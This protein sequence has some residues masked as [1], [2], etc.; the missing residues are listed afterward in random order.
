MASAGNE[1]CEGTLSLV[2]NACSSVSTVPYLGFPYTARTERLIAFRKVQLG[3]VFIED[4]FEL[5]PLD[6]VLRLSLIL[7]MFVLIVRLI[8]RSAL[9]IKILCLLCRVLGR[10]TNERL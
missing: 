9:F 4:K 6:R 8:G 7:L 10:A 2:A 3:P 1:F 5:L